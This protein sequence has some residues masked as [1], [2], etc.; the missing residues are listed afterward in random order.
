MYL[1]IGSLSE[2]SNLQD[3]HIQL[4]KWKKS[5]DVDY[6][7]TKCQV[8]HITRSKTNIPS[9]YNLHNIIPESV[10]AAKYL[11]VTISDDLSWGT[12]INKITEKANQIGLLKRNIKVHNKDLKSVAYKTLVRPQLEYASTVWS[13]HTTTNIYKLESVQR[14]AARWA[15][16]YYRYTSS[17]IS[18]LQ[19]LNWRTL[20]HS[21]S[22]I[23][24]QPIMMYKVTHNLVQYQLWTTPHVILENLDISIR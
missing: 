19:D 11:G 17:V 23:D 22:R 24:S 3:D 10:S 15:T 8:L 14:R 20:D 5:W 1:A 13:P 7:P 21:F 18:M 4:E 6:N 9:K 12:H 16:R 2:I